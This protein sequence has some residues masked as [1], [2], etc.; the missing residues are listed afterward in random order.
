MTAQLQEF[1]LAGRLIGKDPKVV[2]TIMTYEGLVAATEN[3][4]NA[5]IVEIR[6]DQAG[7]QLDAWLET[8]Q[9]LIDQKQPL[10]FTLRHVA[11]GGAWNEEEQDRLKL[12]KELLSAGQLVDIE[13]ASPLSKELIAFAQEIEKPVIVSS[14]NFENTQSDEELASLVKEVASI[15]YVIFKLVTTPQSQEDNRRVMA[16]L[17]HERTQPICLMT[18]GEIGQVTRILFPAEGSCLTYGFIDSPAAPG[19]IESGLLKRMIGDL[20]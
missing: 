2:G 18:M 19:Q 6:L 20:T 12:Y 17:N 5:D 10:I 11:E 14:H 9:K 3:W 16:L 7:S 13:W 1:N 4:P 15:P 8:S